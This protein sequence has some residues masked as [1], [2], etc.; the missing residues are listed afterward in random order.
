MP[1]EY[2]YFSLGGM[3][4]LQ[5]T[6]KLAI[7]E[8]R[9]WPHWPRFVTL[10]FN[11]FNDIR[12]QMQRMEEEQLDNKHSHSNWDF[13]A[14]DAMYKIETFKRSKIITIRRWRCHGK[15]WRPTRTAFTLTSSQWERFKEVM[16]IIQE[17]R[18]DI[19]AAAP[20]C[21]RSE[22]HIHHQHST[23][24]FIFFLYCMRIMHQLQ[25]ACS[26]YS[27]ILYCA[28]SISFAEFSIERM[29]SMQRNLEI[30]LP[31][32]HAVF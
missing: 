24:V 3:R 8:D 1:T 32:T 21:K 4:A 26:L 31:M 13:H 5:L 7:F 10:N 16:T 6:P 20:F 12:L 17:I 19:M 9:R 27:R 25:N 28:C 11:Q 2:Q 15:R 18:P 14:D 22:D 23:F 30:F 29:R